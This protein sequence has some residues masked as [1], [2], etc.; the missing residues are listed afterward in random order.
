M[1]PGAR[2]RRRRRPI[3]HGVATL[4]DDGRLQHVVGFLETPA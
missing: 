3:G 1:T 4:G 2:D